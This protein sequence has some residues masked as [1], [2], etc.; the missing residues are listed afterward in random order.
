MASIRLAVSRYLVRESGQQRGIICVKLDDL[1]SIT[2]LPPAL[3][4]IILEVAHTT[5]K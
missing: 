5:C 4:F 2:I 1:T 3:I